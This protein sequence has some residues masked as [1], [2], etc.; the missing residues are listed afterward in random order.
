MQ[1]VLLAALVVI[2]VLAAVGVVVLSQKSRPP[3]PR[4]EEHL[5]PM[6]NADCRPCHR[7]N[8]GVH[9]LPAS[10]PVQKGCQSCHALAPPGA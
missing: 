2:V 9:P 10:H 5:T 6:G 8:A 4:D 7:Y 1:R 3:M